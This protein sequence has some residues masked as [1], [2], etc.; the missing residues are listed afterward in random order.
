MISHSTR[1]LPGH[2]STWPRVPQELTRVPQE[3]TRVPQEL[4]RV[5]LSPVSDKRQS[6][7]PDSVMTDSPDKSYDSADHL[8]RGTPPDH[9]SRGSPP[10]HL[11]G[12]SPPH[13][14][15]IT[16]PAETES[17]YHHYYGGYSDKSL[18]H[19]LNY[20]ESSKTLSLNY[21]EHGKT[22]PPSSSPLSDPAASSYQN[23]P[24]WYH[25]QSQLHKTAAAPSSAGHW[26]PPPAAAA[27]YQYHP[28]LW[29]SHAAPYNPAAT[30]PTAAAAPAAGQDAQ[31]AA[32]L[33]KHTQ[34][35]AARRCRRCKC[36]N[37]EDGT[38]T[39]DENKKRQHIC[40]VPGCGKVY[41][42][43]SHLKAHLRW[44]AGERPFTCGWVFCNKSFTRSDE[45]QRHLRTHTGEKRFV[46]PECSKR[47]TRSDH[48]NKHIK[49][50]EKRAER[51]RERKTPS[52]KASK[53][54]DEHVDNTENVPNNGQI[55][56]T[57]ESSHQGNY[58]QEPEYLGYSQAAFSQSYPLHLQQ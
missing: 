37:C 34:N 18:S 48:L 24:A 20:S 6:L 13:P 43:T 30:A 19:S 58:K 9:L 50:H 40:H 22:S 31:I 51:E 2:V 42:K 28:Q 56:P 35:M 39:H 4:T 46:C 7:T 5:D 55:L 3:L 54:I 14:L 32:A 27:H 44:H 45:L 26:P 29:G 33:L 16:P 38:G 21:S 8:S 36:P 11:S 17:G 12:G 41:G 25:Y 15:P 23:Y 1:S 57:Q 47:F 53:Q 10:D 49:T 52:P